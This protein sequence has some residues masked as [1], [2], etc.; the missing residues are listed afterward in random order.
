MNNNSSKG[1]T[2]S[3]GIQRI[4]ILAIL[5]VLASIYFFYAKYESKVNDNNTN[6]SRTRTQSE[7]TKPRLYQVGQL[8]GTIQHN[9]KELNFNQHLSNGIANLPGINSAYVMKTDRNAYV[10]ITLDQSGIGTRS[11]RKETNNSGTNIGIYN[12]D[13]PQS[14]LVNPNDVATGHNGAETVQNHDQL[15]H[16]LKQKIA[17]TIRTSDLSIQDVFISGHR[18]FV[19]SM[20]NYAQESWKGHPLTPYIKEFN[21]IVEELFGTQMLPQK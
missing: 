2:F 12:S 13:E 20:N 16:A 21:V 1:P 7:E 17:Q 5:A 10:A 9:N 19:N 3:K 18:K 6:Y 14:D 4:Y 15:S 11:S 8:H